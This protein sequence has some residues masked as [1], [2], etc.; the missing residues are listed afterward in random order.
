MPA[1]SGPRKWAGVVLAGA[2]TFAVGGEEMA[3]P[4]GT[5][6]FVEDPS[7]ERRAVADASGT[8]VLAIGAERGRILTPSPWE[9]DLLTAG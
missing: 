9:T 4:T 8:T 5:V 6:V 3:A 7:L 1:S 2:A